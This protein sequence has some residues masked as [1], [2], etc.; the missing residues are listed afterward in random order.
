M[1]QKKWSW[2]IIVAVALLV[3]HFVPFYIL[4]SVSFKKQMD[5]SSRWSLPGYIN[6]EN[7]T[8]ALEK[9]GLLQAL[10][11][12][13]MITAISVVLIVVIHGGVSAC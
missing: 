6:T 5:L 9:G 3:I 2:K 13:F 11:N 10:I 4:I 1:K 7:F 12:T 8:L